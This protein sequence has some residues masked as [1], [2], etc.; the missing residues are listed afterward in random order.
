MESE[1]WEKDE[2]VE[3][4]ELQK[5]RLQGKWDFAILTWMRFVKASFHF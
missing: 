3:C 4:K 1:Y 2:K 5:N